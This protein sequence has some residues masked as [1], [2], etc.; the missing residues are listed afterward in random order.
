VTPA[1]LVAVPFTAA[2]A[3]LAVGRWRPVAVAVAWV[4][5]LATLGLAAA[6]AVPVWTSGSASVEVWATVPTGWVPITMSTRSDGLTLT[7]AVMVAVVAT[8]VQVYSP[9]YLHG[10]PRYGSYAALV[11]LF[12]A[13]MLLVVVADDLVVLLVGWEVMGI[14]SYFLVGHYWEQPWARSAAVKAFVVTRLGD[15]GFLFG[16][17]V[18]ADLTG[19][20]QLSVINNS[21]GELGCSEAGCQPSTSLTV[22]TLLVLCGVAGKSAQVPLHVWLPDAMAGP[23]PISALIHAATMVAAGVFLVARLFPVLAG[24]PATMAVLAVLACVTMLGGAL[25]ALAQDD[26]KRV[27]AYST[28]SQLA[29][30]LAGLA[31]GGYTGALSHLVGHAAFKAL[32][33]LAAGAVIHTVGSNLMSDMGGLARALPVTYVTMT[34]GLLALAGVP[35]LVGFVGKESIVSAAE[36]AALHGGPLPG[37]AA[38]LVLAST[39]ATVLVTAAYVT[40]AWLLTFHG[41]RRHPAAAGAAPHRTPVTMGGVLVVLAVPVVLLGALALLPDVVQR[42]LAGG[43]GG[44]DDV[45]PLHLSPVT[46]VASLLLVAVGG[47]F[48]F[49]EWS[50]LRR[51]DPAAAL[52]RARGVLAAGFGVDRF[53]DRTVVRP[54]AACARLAA[55]TDREVVV[56]LVTGAGGLVALAGRAVRAAQAGRVQAY[57]AA[58]VVTAV[59]LGIAGGLA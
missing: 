44:V 25:A 33:F 32:L 14:C 22:A 17:L 58:V 5:A 51:S 28:S 47:L 52:G 30:M 38:W 43:V 55:A 12:T 41:P 9:A 56:P 36:E 27:L 3:G 10:E 8:A 18:L 39:L 34:I 50:R 24:V 19:S 35:P 7:V 37:W 31:V 4:G 46:T 13:A 16:V 40:R 21:L 26:L 20:F 49:A 1:V 2:V 48:A 57:L 29:Y 54:V 42:L 11:S 53:Y 23:T 59:V 6:L 45:E 15:V